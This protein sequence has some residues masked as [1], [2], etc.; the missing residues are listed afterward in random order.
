MRC[1]KWILAAV[2]FAATV[3]LAIATATM[4][5]NNVVTR[6]RIHAVEEWHDL[7]RV[8]LERLRAEWREATGTH[9][10][11]QR[12]TEFFEGAATREEGL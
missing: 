11:R 6:Q 12:L 3:G 7:Q 10:L 9:R 8:R 4:A 5:A 1:L 2:L